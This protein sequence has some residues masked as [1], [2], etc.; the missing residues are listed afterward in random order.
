M[1]LHLYLPDEIAKTV[2]QR[3]EARGISVSRYLA[4]LVRREVAG[5]WPAG[6]FEDVVGKWD[7]PLERSAE[8]ETE[9]RES[10]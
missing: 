5:G 2:Q 3:A 7:G 4:E 9:R 8:G 6:F 1:Q 10:L